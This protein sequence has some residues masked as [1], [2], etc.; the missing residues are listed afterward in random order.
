MC[1]NRRF[2]SLDLVT[3][4]LVGSARVHFGLEDIGSQI[5]GRQTSPIKR[6]LVL[7]N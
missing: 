5:S 4:V 2:E 6:N 7:H 1:L 3:S